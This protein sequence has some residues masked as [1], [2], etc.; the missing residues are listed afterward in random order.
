M[1]K[2]H[3][4]RLLINFDENILLPKW[5]RKGVLCAGHHFSETFDSISK[6][7]PRLAH[8]LLGAGPT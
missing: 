7:N 5:R 4:A 6:K 8:F 3:S 2:L 1:N